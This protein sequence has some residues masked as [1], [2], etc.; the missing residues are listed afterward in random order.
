MHYRMS[1]ASGSFAEEI[2]LEEA[3]ARNKAMAQT[4]ALTTSTQLLNDKTTN[5]DA[6]RRMG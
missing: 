3:L 1:Q 6:V 2:H 5:E 4:A